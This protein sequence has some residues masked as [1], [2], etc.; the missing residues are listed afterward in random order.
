MGTG[1]SHWCFFL[2]IASLPKLVVKLRGSGARLAIHQ[3]TELLS[4]AEHGLLKEIVGV[5][6]RPPVF[7]VYGIHASGQGQERIDGVEE[8]S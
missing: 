2:A 4:K 1:D 3:G 6:D 7:R 8:G 5:I